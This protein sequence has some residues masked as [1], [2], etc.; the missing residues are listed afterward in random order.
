VTVKDPEPKPMVYRLDELAR[1]ASESGLVSER[2][3]ADRLDV[4]L[5]DG[6]RLAFCN[7]AAEDDTLV[8]FDGTPWH[9]HGVVSFLA[10][11]PY[12]VECDELDVLIGL[13]SGEL[14]VVSQFVD[15]LLQDRWIEHK[16]EPLDL[17]YLRPG[18]ELR[19]LRLPDT[20]KGRAG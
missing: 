11:S 19:V 13:C 14:V 16:K 20:G 15:G 4:V 9:S 8:G 1:L 12:F 6:C 2:V 17:K 7:L 3:G 5:F 18:E 10:G